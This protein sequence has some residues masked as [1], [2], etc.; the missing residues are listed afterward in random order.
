M[1]TKADIPSRK[2]TIL[3]DTR[4]K[5]D[6]RLYKIGF[7]DKSEDPIEAYELCK[8]DTGD[9]AIKE[10]PKL[11]CI[12]RKM[13]GKELYTNIMHDRER[14]MREFERMKEFSHKWIVFQQ[15]YEEFRDSR[16]WTGVKD[17][18]KSMSIVEGW[19]MALVMQG[20][21][22]IFAGDQADHWVKRVFIKQ[23]DNHRKSLREE[24]KREQDRNT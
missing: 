18:K 12:E 2:F 8:I 14:L 3:V 19:L 16:N 13:D 23:Y 20:I 5:P 22:F 10:A 9:Y 7:A 6:H 11:V 15:T 17:P 21:H 4:E 1:I 24:L